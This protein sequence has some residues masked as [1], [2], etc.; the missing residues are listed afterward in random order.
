MYKST[1]LT[2]TTLCSSCGSVLF[3]YLE[4]KGLDVNKTMFQENCC[5]DL[6]EGLV[7]DNCSVEIVV[8]DVFFTV[9]IGDEILEDVADSISEDIGGCEH[10]EGNNRGYYVHSYNNDPF[11]KSS[12]I[13]FDDVRE[14]DV[15][16]YLYN[17]GV[18]EEFYE[19]FARLIVCPCG[20]GREPRHQRHNP[21]GGV[22]ELTDDI[23]TRVGIS[24]FWGFDDSA[25]CKFAEV[26]GQS[27]S[28]DELDEFRDYLVNYPMLA[29]KH[30]IG[31]AIFN[32]LKSHFESEHYTIIKP[33]QGL[34]YRGRTRKKDSKV[35]YTKDQMWS[36]PTGKPQHGRY[37]TV[38]VPVLYLCD[39]LEAVPYEINPTHEDV[40][41]VAVFKMENKLRIFDIGDFDPEFQGF[42]NEKNEDT[43]ILKK[44]YL[45]PN[46]IGS[47]CSCIGYDGV[48]YDG[49]HSQLEYTNYA[50]FS[51]QE[52]DTLIIKGDI[53]TYITN[54]SY[55][56]SNE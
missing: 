4:S 42:F 51:V 21:D 40:I 46:Y 43:N 29:Y 55:Q 8:D 18:P 1:G 7:C 26:Y 31:Q 32:V 10:C 35:V 37:N 36:P 49:V 17:Q 48:K 44:A 39:L 56:L 25:F 3:D 41:D 54:L 22:F 52:S 19:L 11:D 16:E 53:S 50:L 14:T 45:L 28:T 30:S 23:Y 13:E 2:D 20:Y 5:E 38:G 6:D 34:F 27:F 15:S 24:K 47:C 33:S 9:E 12:R